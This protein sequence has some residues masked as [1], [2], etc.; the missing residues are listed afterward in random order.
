MLGGP[1]TSHPQRLSYPDSCSRLRALE[2][3]DGSEDPPLPS[4]VPRFD[5]DVP[6]VSFFRTLVD[7]CDLGGLTLPRTFF[8]RSEV[9][10]VSFRGS[11]LHESNLCWNDFIECDFTEADLERSDLRASLFASCGFR[12]ANLEGCD[13]RRATF[14]AC[15]FQGAKMSGAILTRGQRSQLRLTSDQRK[16][17]QWNFFSGKA[18]EGG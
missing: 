13:L 10:G 2:L 3:I 4:Q 6:G 1:V 11:D 16:A 14:E 17:V 5:D 18:P 7:G 15:D 12:N 8:G 9:N